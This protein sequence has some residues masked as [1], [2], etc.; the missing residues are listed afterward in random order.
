M[1]TVHDRLPGAAAA[2]CPVQLQFEAQF[3]LV[4]S[5]GPS[6]F[7]G[8][9]GVAQATL[10]LDRARACEAASVGTPAERAAIEKLLAAFGKFRLFIEAQQ[11][12]CVQHIASMRGPVISKAAA[13]QRL[14]DYNLSQVRSL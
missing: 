8:G 4:Q 14:N 5:L 12:Q 10:I 9:I 11:V 3:G 1:T 2:A 7:K 6:F 13:L